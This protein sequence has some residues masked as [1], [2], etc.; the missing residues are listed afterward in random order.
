[1]SE[2]NQE[3]KRA[4]ARQH[5]IFFISL[6]VI[7]LLIVS[8]GGFT[9]FVKGTPILVIPAE[10][11]ETAE[12]D[13]T[14]GMAMIVDGTLFSLTRN[15][16]LTT[17]A[18]GFEVDERVIAADQEGTQQIIELVPLPGQIILKTDKENPEVEWFVDGKTVSLSKDLDLTIEA[19]R[20]FV[21]VDPKYYR[22]ESLEIEVGRGEIVEQIVSMQELAVALDIE[23]VP[24]GADIEIDGQPAGKSPLMTELSGGRHQISIRK[25]GFAA[26][27]E[28]MEIT[29]RDVTVTRNYRLKVEPAYVT[30]DIT[31]K[32]GQLTLNGKPVK[33]G[34]RI[35]LTP[36]RSYD[37]KYVKPGFFG[38]EKSI[39]VASGT[40]KALTFALKAEIGNVT[41]SSTPKAVIVV[42]GQ[43]VGETPVNLRLQ[44]V[45]HRIQL[46]RQGYR[47]QEK[48]IT[49]S[50]AR[51]VRWNADLLTI[52]A[53]KKSEA[54]KSYVNA[55]G[56]QMKLFKPSA[57]VMGAPRHE[58]GQRANEFV[59][60]VTLDRYFYA[61][62]REVTQRQ[63]AAFKPSA[64][65]VAQ[66]IPVTNISWIEAARFCNWL[67]KQEG[68]TPFYKFSGSRFTGF[69]A[70]ANGYRLLSE[71]EWEWLAR[72]AGRQVETR[73][74]W[75][76]E[77]VIPPGSGN[78]SDESAR[79]K[80]RF[81]V[82]DYDDGF[83]GLA[84]VGSFAA[85]Y[86]GL[87]DLFG[88]V[89]EWVNDYYS[90]TPPA[91]GEVFEN[92]LGRPS[93]DKHV[94]KGSNWQS[95]T[96]TELRPSYRDAGDEGRKNVGFRIGRYL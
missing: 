73:F 93:G 15:P 21:E 80:S 43:P 14:S 26:I 34:A 64:S 95:G 75:G 13:V 19:G 50:A 29:N 6:L 90:L 70:S 40:T 42:N 16:Q 74:P 53:A 7:I 41:I 59:K 38:Q 45:P 55:V 44:A 81:Y 33:R 1:M 11:E 48:K 57:F 9:L 51:D 76:D 39:K 82:P 85:D 54:K 4:A 63:F 83:A 91:K 18:P 69:T 65:V 35:P 52:E 30:I 56:M 23:T 66:N 12:L 17:K 86:S 47:V 94:I 20:Y 49:P 62:R 5:R 84:P 2:F 68:L 24:D 96:L 88:N 22:K 27:E 32:G 89:S 37:V 10:I 71:A 36:S 8:V 92:P 77:A 25:T 60:Q 72:K 28:L 79:G 78:I 31:P 3:L 87:N 61:S 58:T 46:V 67:S